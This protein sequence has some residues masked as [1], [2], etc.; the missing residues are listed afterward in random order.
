MAICEYENAKIQS[1]K[2]RESSIDAHCVRLYTVLDNFLDFLV[3][4]K[5]HVANKDTSSRHSPYNKTEVM[6]CWGLFPEDVMFLKF[7]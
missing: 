2:I 7:D 5:Q 3:L 1:S 6:N 4:D